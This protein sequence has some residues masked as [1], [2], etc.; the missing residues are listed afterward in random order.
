MGVTTVV[1]GERPPELE[2]FLA[3]R[4]TLGLDG[5][6]EVWEGAYHVAPHAHRADF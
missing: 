4:C 1:V 2:S 3:R 6:D 5:H